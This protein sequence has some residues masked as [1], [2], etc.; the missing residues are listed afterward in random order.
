[1]TARH[2]L[3]VLLIT[4]LGVTLASCDLVGDAGTDTPNI[5]GVYVANQGNFGDG[6]GSVSVF[7]PTTGQVQPTAIE[8]LGSI[9]QGIAVRD[10]SLLLTAN[11]AARVDLFSTNGP[12]QT[13][14]VTGVTSPRYAAF[15]GPSTA[16]LTDQSFSGPSAVQVLDLDRPQPQITAT[17]EV[18]GSPEG[19]AV[20]ADRAYAALGAFGDTTLVASI[21]TRQN[22]LDDEIDVGCTPRDVTADETGDVFALCSNTAEAV[23]LEGATGTVTSRLSL[24]DTAETVFGVGDPSTYSPGARELYV[25]TDTGVLR[26]DTQSNTVEATVD[27]GLSAAPGAV[28]YDASRQELYVARPAGFTERGT[29]TV[30][31]RDGTQTDSFRAGIAP[32]DI[33]FQQRSR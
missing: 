30:H 11:S 2:S 27:V 16:Y 10:T 32:T 18:S 31:D 5:D 26:I 29:V 3:F 14:Q 17:I 22:T 8:G 25:A 21:N 23:I 20:T 1:M 24:P 28:A 12:T 13:A 6:N 15:D 9:V 33:A 7:D 4:T 19:I